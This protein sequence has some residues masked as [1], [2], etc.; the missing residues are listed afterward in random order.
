MLENTEINEENLLVEEK[1]E[2]NFN[3]VLTDI[4]SGYYENIHVAE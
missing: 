3:N 1:V 2:I 4:V